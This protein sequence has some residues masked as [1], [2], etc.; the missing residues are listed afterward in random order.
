MSKQDVK[1]TQSTL[2][3]SM[4][5]SEVPLSHYNF[6]MKVGTRILQVQIEIT[7]DSLIIEALETAIDYFV[8]I[9]YDQDINEKLDNYEVYSADP[10]GNP[11]Q[12]KFKTDQLLQEIDCQNFALVVKKK[13]ALLSI[14]KQP[15]QKEI[16]ITDKLEIPKFRYNTTIAK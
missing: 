4:R 8:Q 5:F 10:Q 16:R 1:S 2:A 11:L 3:E 6:S 14:L 12:T 7:S 9:Y 13:G 15:L